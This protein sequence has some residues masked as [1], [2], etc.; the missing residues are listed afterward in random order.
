[1]RTRRLGRNGP[2]VSEVG[3]GCMGMSDFYGPADEGESIATVHAALDAG[4]TMFDTGDFYGM[5]HNEMLLGRALKGKRDK[6]FIAVKFGAQRTVTGN[7][8]GFAMQP[9]A[10]KT[11]LAY[12]LRRLGTDYIDLYMPARVDASVPFEDTI[13][14]VAD[15]VKEGYVRH[16]GVSEAGVDSIRRAQAVHPIAALQI[17]YSL[18]SRGVEDEI[19]PALRELGIGVTAYGV[20]AR[21]LLSGRIGRDGVSAPGDFRG[22]TPRFQGEN[23]LRN[24]TLV[25]ALTTLATRMNATPAQIAIAWAHHRG[26]D[27]IPLIGARTSER[28]S[29]ALRALDI[30]LSPADVAA[31]EAAVPAEAVAGTRYA[32]AQ[33]HHLDSERRSA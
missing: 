4:I 9:A 10:V 29:E 15:L 22:Q 25:E 18:A 16:I 21:G 6:A 7:F 1:M 3:L 8:I 28:L 20:L 5:G 11:A 24:L 23:L 2:L 27:I 14:A 30:T 31:I 19:L 13:G 12:T 32:A 33:M 26:D 17:E